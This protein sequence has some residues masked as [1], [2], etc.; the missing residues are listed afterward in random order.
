M[1]NVDTPVASEGYPFIAAGAVL[2]IIL[3]ILGW[4]ILALGMLA[5]TIFI[6]FFFRNP[7]R[8]APE[9]EA[10]IVAP[11]DGVVIFLGNAF[12]EHLGEEMLKI[13][14]FMSV[15]NVHVNRVPF[16]GTVADPF[17]VRGKFLDVRHERA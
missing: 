13:S 17:Y 6:T 14:I 16:S 15:F 10:A 4:K 1:K 5:V 2:T 12:E 7:E 8:R 3:A 9:E 11:A